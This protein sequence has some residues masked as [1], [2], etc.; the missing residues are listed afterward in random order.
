MTPAIHP[1]RA[2]SGRLLSF[3]LSLPSH[4]AFRFLCCCCLCSLFVLVPH[5]IV[6]HLSMYLDHIAGVR[7]ELVLAEQ[8][9]EAQ[10]AVV[11]TM[12]HEL[13]NPHGAVALGIVETQAVLGETA[14]GV[15]ALTSTLAR[16]AAA[17]HGA[18][19]TGTGTGRKAARVSEPASACDLDTDGSISPVRL[20][21]DNEPA[22]VSR[23]RASSSDAGGAILPLPGPSSMALSLLDPEPSILTS[24]GSLDFR[25]QLQ[26]RAHELAPASPSSSRS[27][28]LVSSSGASASQLDEAS[29]VA[30]ESLEQ[31]REAQEL[32]GIMLRSSAQMS[33]LLDGLLDLQKIDSGSLT[34]ELIPTALPALVEDA[35]KQLQPRLLTRPELS[36]CIDIDPALAGGRLLLGDHYRLLQCVMNLLVNG[37]RYARSRLV[38][39]AQLLRVDRDSP[40][41]ALQRQRALLAAFRDLGYG[42][43]AAAGAMVASGSTSAVSNVAP[44]PATAAWYAS[45]SPPATHAAAGS[46]HEGPRLLSAVSPSPSSRASSPHRKPVATAA[47]GSISQ[48]LAAAYV[49]RAATIRS[50]PHASQPSESGGSPGPSQPMSFVLSPPSPPLPMSLSLSRASSG[51]SSV[52]SG[53]GASAGMSNLNRGG[54][55]S[56]TSTAAGPLAILSTAAAAAAA[57]VRATA[58]QAVSSGSSAAFSS[59]HAAT[60]DT[61]TDAAIVAALLPFAPSA[62]TR[63]AVRLDPTVALSGAVAA[64]P[65]SN[66]ALDGSLG[67][68]GQLADAHEALAGD[69]AP[70]NERT[71]D[72]KLSGA[73]SSASSGSSNSGSGSSKARGGRGSKHSSQSGMGSFHSTVTVTVNPL[74]V[75]SASG[76]LGAC[77]A[78]ELRTYSNRSHSSSSSSS[79]GID[80]L[81]PSAGAG[82]PT[83]LQVAAGMRV[84]SGTGGRSARSSPPG[85]GLAA[86]AG[87]TLALLQPPPLPLSGPSGI[88]SAS[89]PL[90]PVADVVEGSAASAEAA[91]LASPTRRQTAAAASTPVPLPLPLPFPLALPLPPSVPVLLGGDEVYTVR[92]SV[93]DDGCGI[94]AAQLP[95][96]FKDFSQVGVSMQQGKGYGLGLAILQRL[97][98]RHGGSVG[99]ESEYGSGSTSGSTFYID[100]PLRALVLEGGAS[101]YAGPLSSDGN[102]DNRPAIGVGVDGAYGENLS[103]AVAEAARSSATPDAAT[104]GSS[105]TARTAM[106]RFDDEPA[107][108][109]RQLPATPCA[110][111]TLSP[112]A[113]V[114]AASSLCRTGSSSGSPEAS[115]PAAQTIG[116][117]SDVKP[118]LTQPGSLLA[119]SARSFSARESSS[120]PAASESAHWQL[121]S[122]PK[123]FPQVAAA[124]AAESRSPPL[125]A[126]PS[127]LVD[128]GG[129]TSASPAYLT[130]PAS[131][132]STHGSSGTGSAGAGCAGIVLLADD[133][134]VNRLLLVRTL[135]R[136]LPGV[137]L[138]E[139]DDGQALVEAFCRLQGQPVPEPEPGPAL[140]LS[141]LTTRTH[142]SQSPTPVDV[143]SRIALRHAAAD[144][145]ARSPDRGAQPSSDVSDSA[146]AQAVDD[147]RQ[148]HAAPV[149]AGLPI[150]CVITDYMMPR[151]T[152]GEAA[153]ALRAFGFQ[154]PV[155]GITGNALSDDVRRFKAAGA[156]AVFAKPVDVNALIESMQLPPAAFVAATSSASSPR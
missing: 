50:S 17:S 86:A 27:D 110:K 131:P 38:L 77:A 71:S 107:A 33:R 25:L 28:Q 49:A 1:C 68:N 66:P 58:T 121:P 7:R 120:A 126:S 133:E 96:L 155:I 130:S 128:A 59:L 103:S 99:V 22:G 15:A 108:S 101:A 10:K 93:Q 148:V 55:G 143:D 54:S 16:L 61:T 6:T 112:A 114:G 129:V 104:H 94:P 100:V 78:D 21:L 123:S 122:T 51:H 13:R 30:R 24:S 48:P 115:T 137:R 127:A 134:A 44:A 105:G 69:R 41:A 18:T 39:R 140:A 79:S 144:A 63:Y 147:R 88:V 56:G 76:G 8:R 154:R 119:P 5:L 36:F 3:L 142:T 83:S 116:A 85:L 97:V 40:A 73:V 141:G 117:L 26:Q 90:P 45:A 149:P 9:E 35:A 135:K 132:A 150:L 31:L 19:G 109:M 89:T 84:V 87:H 14:R 29:T 113:R 82:A 152:G 32:L 72:D 65:F 43:G 74:Q 12:L 102:R 81:S 156:S 75:A 53:A 60:V 11:R 67:C 146:M 23:E 118:P 42:S 145:A 98:A 2:L 4:A 125:F 151:L 70:D 62:N 95:S 80:R 91:A 138:V 92:I 106:G 124:V 46:V 111:T 64:Q 57:A 20:A 136:R 34:I 153:S 139:A 52:A 47:S 37:V